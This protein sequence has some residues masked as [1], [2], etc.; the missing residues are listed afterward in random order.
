MINYDDVKKEN[1]KSHNQNQ[2]Q[3]LDHPYRKLIIGDSGSVK[4]AY[5]SIS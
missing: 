5:Y 2:P 3:I 1:L 4:K